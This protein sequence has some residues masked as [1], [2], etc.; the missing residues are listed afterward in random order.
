MK[1]LKSSLLA[2][3]VTLTSGA[4][5][6]SGAAI[7]ALRPLR[8]S[9][10]LSQADRADATPNDLVV[11]LTALNFKGLR[12]LYRKEYQ[13][14]LQTYQQ[15]F[16]EAKAR[17]AILR[18]GESLEAGEPSEIME[19]AQTGM[20]NAYLFMGQYPQAIAILQ[21]LAP[22]LKI[23]FGGNVWSRLAY[24]QLAT[25][26]PAGAEKSLRRA[27]EHWEYVRSLSGSDAD[28]VTLFE[29][30][31]YTYRLLQKA[32]VAQKKYE[33]ALEVAEASRS[34][35]LV[36]LL[37]Q[38]TINPKF[39]VVKPP[40]LKEIQQVAQNHQTTLVL[41]SIVGD[42]K[43]ILGNEPDTETDLFIWVVSPS[44]TVEF[45]QVALKTLGQSLENLNRTSLL[46]GLVRDSRSSIGVATR[47]IA[48]REDETQISRFVGTA[49]V[50][51]PQLQELHRLLIQPIASL[52]PKSP[53]ARVT[54]IPQGPLFLVPFPALQ[55]SANQYLIQK[56]T[57]LTAPS[58][59]VLELAR[60]QKASLPR[61]RKAGDV[62]LVGNPKMPLYSPNDKTPPQPL[63]S[64]PGAEK[65]ARTIAPLL[66]TEPLIGE[67]ATI[68]EVRKRLPKSRIIHLA[69][70][71]IFDLDP[72]LNEF[73]VV[74]GENIPKPEEMGFFTTPGGVVIG[75][76]VTIN[77]MPANVVLARQKVTRIEM[78]GLLALAPTAQDSGFL[79]AKEI[80]TTRLQAELAVLSACDTGRGRI[81]GD[82]VV[83]LVRALIGA[84]V[85][86]V[87]VS[88]WAVPDAPTAALMSE[89]YRQLAAKKD[90]AQALRQAMLAT[91]QQY[92]DP[93]DWGAFTLIGEPE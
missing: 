92:P 54:F 67:V 45:H 79:S 40:T 35:A 5:P 93:R 29:Q 46:A 77:G 33:T 80:L 32:L 68:T 44:G 3:L 22:T 14:A 16:K 10:S 56:H 61:D 47:G 28:N 31:A 51:N 64:L 89:F 50:R 6:F 62:L 21:D 58:I 85:P 76:G 27:I 91:L 65:E 12:E 49:A 73:G 48:F 38:R 78:P 36:E 42:E 57:V 8:V 81:T 23:G 19:A 60:K 69:T 74:V 25:G 83:G 11:R 72:N 66:K 13:T 26:N 75:A 52:L 30:Q 20:A 18:E 37:A 1:F 53:E 7:E 71:G 82:G 17:E 24:A 34:R 84:G 41:Y 86:T 4:V 88:L 39:R 2:L 63:L 55:D 9:Q 70:H 59:Q 87:I 90:K 43:R 15:V